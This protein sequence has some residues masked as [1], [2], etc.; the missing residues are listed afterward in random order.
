MGP[1]EAWAIQLQGL[2][3]LGAPDRLSRADVDLVVIDRVTTVKGSGNFAL[4]AVVKQVHASRGKV[5]PR[6]LCLAYVNV[7]QAEDYRTYW[8]AGWSPPK[9]GAP[10]EPAFILGRDP[11]GWRGNFPVAYWDPRWRK[12]VFGTDES[13]VDGAIREGFDGVV[14]DWVMGYQNGDVIAAA[15]V[16]RVDPAAEMARLIRDLA[17]HARA[18]RPGFLVFPLNAAG[19][20]EARP[21]LAAVLDGV[22]QED[23]TF[24]GKASSDWDDPNNADL[25]IAATGDWST[26]THVRR[27][28]ALRAKGLTILTVD[29]ATEERN[30]DAARALARRYGFVPFVTRTP[31]DRIPDEYLVVR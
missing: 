29:Y 24:A 23:V 9:D 1:I 2:T 22:V 4:P 6:K 8:G 30:R 10:G 3:R 16:S 11:E 5:R 31:L 19:L 21:D 26:E 12:V 20:L 13:L 28:S 25:A 7:G 18:Q 27:L 17:V 15:K 14:L